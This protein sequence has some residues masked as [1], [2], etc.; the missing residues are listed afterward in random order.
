MGN[1]VANCKEGCNL[2]D[3]YITMLDKEAEKRVMGMYVWKYKKI[4]ILCSFFFFFVGVVVAIPLSLTGQ[5][6]QCQG[7]F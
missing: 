7:G 1:D 3:L 5:I 4:T 2:G 6:R